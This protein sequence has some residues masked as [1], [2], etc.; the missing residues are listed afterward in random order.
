MAKRDC[1]IFVPTMNKSK[2]TTYPKEE[3]EGLWLRVEGLKISGL[4]IEGHSPKG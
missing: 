2:M 4:R 3:V 1:E